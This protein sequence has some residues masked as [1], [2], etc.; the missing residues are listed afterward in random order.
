MSD[1]QTNI[2]RCAR[3]INQIIKNQER[4]KREKRN[5]LRSNPD[6]IVFRHGFQINVFNIFKKIDNNVD[7]FSTDLEFIKKK[8]I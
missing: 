6:I 7:T 3:R 5:I 1:L 2:T 4:G 8:N